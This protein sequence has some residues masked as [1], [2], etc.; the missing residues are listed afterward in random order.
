[1][2]LKTSVLTLSFLTSIRFN[3]VNLPVHILS[4]YGEDC[5]RLFWKYGNVSK[6]LPN[7]GMTWSFLTS[8]KFTAL[9][10]NLFDSKYIREPCK[11][12]N[13]TRAGKINFLSTR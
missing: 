5:K 13:S 10:L 8:A 2:F 11:I 1:M 3:H 7:D 6:K 4:T 9:P 12:P